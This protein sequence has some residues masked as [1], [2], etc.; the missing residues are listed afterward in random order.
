MKFNLRF[1][2]CILIASVL[3]FSLAACGGNKNDQE[4]STAGTTQTE[5]TKQAEAPKDPTSFSFIID[6]EKDTDGFKEVAK[7]AESKLNIV[8]KFEKFAGDQIAQIARA[9]FASGEMPDFIFANQATDAI[10]QYGDNFI[11][12]SGDWTKNFD[13]NIL[14]GPYSSNGKIISLPVG[15]IS[16]GVVFYN[17]KIFETLKL[18]IPKTWGE[19][20]NVCEKIK[21]SGKV[22]FFVSLKDGWTTQLIPLIGFEREFKG[23]NPNEIMEA[24][25]TNR[26]KYTDL[27]LFKDSFAKLLELKSKGYINK[28]YVSDSY[29]IAKKAIAE[30][31]AAMYPMGAWVV[32]DFKK[33]YADKLNDIGAF[34]L[35]FDGNDLVPAWLSP[36]IQV[37]K[38][39]KNPDTAKQ[40]IEYMGSLEG[41]G[42]YFKKQPGIPLAKELKVEGLSTLEQEIY[43]VYNTNPCSEFEFMRKGYSKYALDK[44][45]QDFLVG[46]K[47]SVDVLKALQADWE[48]NAKA[49]GDANFK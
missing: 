19:L 1:T 25:N 43:T 39:C 6:T 24:I 45:M 10:T 5:E 37:T 2:L 46:A 33:D 4:N 9:R 8:F 23:K 21:V 12:I 29:D 14:K 49:A 32:G 31:T 42:I 11:D 20:L 35:P 28:T 38:G 27:P 41:Q 22:P 17:K 26:L 7:E 15:Q 34:A 48:K 3:I 36:S 44:G 40:F 18:D 47:T 13:E 30:G 16:P